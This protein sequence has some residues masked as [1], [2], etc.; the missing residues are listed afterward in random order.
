MFDFCQLLWM[1]PAFQHL[2]PVPN[3]SSSFPSTKQPSLPSSGG[4]IGKGKFVSESLIPQSVAL[5]G[6]GLMWELFY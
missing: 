3:F 5:R 4:Q 1:F 2:K 6:P